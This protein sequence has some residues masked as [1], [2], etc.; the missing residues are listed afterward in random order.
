MTNTDALKLECWVGGRGRDSK[1]LCL[2]PHTLCGNLTL[3]VLGQGGQ[4]LSIY[5]VP[6]L[7]RGSSIILFL[8][9]KEGIPTS[10]HIHV[11]IHPYHI[12]THT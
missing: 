4:C 12:Y 3:C 7:L 2:T 8:R 1:E 9:R 6:D 5:N 11:Y 10:E